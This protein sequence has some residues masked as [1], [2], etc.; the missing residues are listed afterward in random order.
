MLIHLDSIP[1]KSERHSCRLMFMVT[2]GKNV[3]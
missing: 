1:V 3:V 2:G